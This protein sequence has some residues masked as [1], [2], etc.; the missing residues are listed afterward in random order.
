MLY[1]GDNQSFNMRRNKERVAQEPDYSPASLLISE[2]VE[3]WRRVAASILTPQEVERPRREAI[4]R[5]AQQKFTALEKRYR[6]I[7]GKKVSLHRQ[8][9]LCVW[10]EKES[11]E[12]PQFPL[13]WCEEED[14]PHHPRSLAIKKAILNFKQANGALQSRWLT[15]IDLLLGP[16]LQQARAKA[17]TAFFNPEQHFYYT[18]R[19]MVRKFIQTQVPLLRDRLVFRFTIMC[20]MHWH[21]MP[22]G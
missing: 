4:I 7:L 2:E 12:F 10:L 20:S 15:V 17:A 8:S 5:R 19:E 18:A 1:S 16:R 21:P 13:K 9:I 6:D 11:G 22:P 14:T 3:R